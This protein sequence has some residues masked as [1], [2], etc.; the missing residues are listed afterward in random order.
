MQG[1]AKCEIDSVDLAV[2]LIER[3]SGKNKRENQDRRWGYRREW[4]LWSD[5]IGKRRRRRN[6]E[7]KSGSLGREWGGKRGE[8]RD[9]VIGIGEEK[10]IVIGVGKLEMCGKKKEVRERAGN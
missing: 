7:E 8:G 6:G 3:H 1:R 10:E 5:R 4:F 9:G 2:G